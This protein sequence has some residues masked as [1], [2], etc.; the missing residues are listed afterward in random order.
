MSGCRAVEAA[1]TEEMVTPSWQDVAERWERAYRKIAAQELDLLAELERRTAER[2]EAF[3]RAEAAEKR[4]QT[5]EETA[6]QGARNTGYYRD[7]VVAIGETIGLQAYVSDDGSV[8]QDVLCAKVPEL[9]VALKD[10]A[11]SAEA[12]LR[13]AREVLGILTNEYVPWRENLHEEGCVGVSSP[14]EERD[15]EGC[16]CDGDY[17]IEC[18]RALLAKLAAREGGT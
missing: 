7:I 16:R 4:A 12:L 3:S 17:D 5:W 11:E 1:M 10:R 6:C 2:D 18:V 14:P 15:G 13:E 8:Q 9:V